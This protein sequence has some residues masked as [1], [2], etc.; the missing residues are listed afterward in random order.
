MRI[1]NFQNVS[2]KSPG[3][4]TIAQSLQL[5]GVYIPGSLSFNNVVALL[6]NSVITANHSYTLSFGLFSLNGGTLSLANSAVLQT[7]GTNSSFTSWFSLATSA[8]QDITPGNWWLGFIETTGGGYGVRAYRENI[9]GI[10]FGSVGTI[11]YGG[12]F[13][14]GHHTTQGLPSAVCT[15]DCVKR[16]STG[17]DIG[18]RFNYIVISA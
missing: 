4:Q 1:N 17:A 11:P 18:S 14:G 10:G 16:D 15:S 13:E 12:I 9:G 5:L 6:G 7:N 8:T 2:G 3:I